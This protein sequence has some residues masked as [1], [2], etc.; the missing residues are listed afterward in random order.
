MFM[1][2][3]RT[4]Q[5]S[6]DIIGTV[7]RALTLNAVALC[8]WSVCAQAVAEEAA[9]VTTDTMLYCRMLA[10]RVEASGTMPPLA[11]ALWLEG[12]AMCEHGQVRPGLAR[13]RRA[14]MIVNGGDNH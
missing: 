13:L 6:C 9:S 5:A 8:L 10:A 3:P 14:M 12:R 2:K 1:Q 11:H 4:R 7:T